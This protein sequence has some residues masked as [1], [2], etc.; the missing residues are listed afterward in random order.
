MRKF[1]DIAIAG[2]YVYI[3]AGVDGIWVLDISDPSAP[4]QIAHL[5]TQPNL[6]AMDTHILISGNLAYLLSYDILDTIDISD[7]KSPRHISSLEIPPYDS[8]DK[9]SKQ[10]TGF[11]KTANYIYCFEKVSGDNPLH[12][13]K[14]IDIK[15]LNKK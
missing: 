6:T 15:A 7:P 13:I 3:A 4:R 2:Q 12:L 14:I 8:V 5:I 9:K 1:S 11:A 10:Y